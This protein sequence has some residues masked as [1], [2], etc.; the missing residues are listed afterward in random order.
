MHMK[1]ALIL[2]VLFAIA[3]PAAAE[4]VVSV[5]YR[6]NPAGTP[7]QSDLGVIR[8]LGFNGVTWPRSSKAGTAELQRLA[9]KVGLKVIVA[10]GPVAL[11]PES[12]MRAG[13][14]VDIVITLASEAMVP[15]LAWRAVAHGARSISFDSGE[16][17]GAGL[18]EK[19][20]DLKA[21]ARA[22]IT[23]ARQLTANARLVDVLKPGPGVLMSRDPGSK[24]P[25][26]H[27]DSALDVVLLDGGRSWVIV[28]TNAAEE[29]GRAVVRLPAGA[30]YA[31]WI[32]WIDGTTLAMV[33]EAAGPKWNLQIAGGA[34][35]VY[36]I[37]KV[38]KLS[39]VEF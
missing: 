33:D 24:D 6:G 13:E 22:A 1:S 38:M 10:D 30:P 26:L 18:E 15:A 27:T 28:A 25:G 37:D 36:V 2:I 16:A 34:A 17:I 7:R 5:W 3:A 23:I 11:T 8:A 12:A 35:R 31:V 21:W 9:E 19:N 4:P 20:G 39:R 14:R 32:S 29:S